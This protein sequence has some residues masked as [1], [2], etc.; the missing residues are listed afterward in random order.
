MNCLVEVI[1]LVFK[2]LWGYYNFDDLKDEIF[3]NWVG[4]GYQVY[5]ICNGCNKYNEKVLLVY[6][7]FNDN[8]VFK[9]FDGN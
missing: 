8:F 1:Y 3:V 4:K 6:V 5:Y 2:F 7:V 9:E